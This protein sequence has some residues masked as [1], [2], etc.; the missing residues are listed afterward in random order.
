M[1]NEKCI[2]CKKG[3]YKKAIVKIHGFDIDGWRCNACGEECYSIGEFHRAAD[4]LL[5][6]KSIDLLASDPNFDKYKED[7]EA[8]L[9]LVNTFMEDEIEYAEFFGMLFL[10]AHTRV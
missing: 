6:M 4:H 5:I 2:I 10:V 3:K 9:W 7:Y 8:W 1:N